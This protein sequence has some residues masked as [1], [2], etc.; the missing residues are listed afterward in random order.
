VLEIAYRTDDASAEQKSGRK[1][2]DRDRSGAH[3][4][5]ISVSDDFSVSIAD[6]AITA[7]FF[8][9]IAGA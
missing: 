1:R 6:P 9:P 5:R 3:P 2:S 7:P 4:L 8:I